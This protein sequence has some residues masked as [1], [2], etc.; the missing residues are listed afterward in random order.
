MTW[1]DCKVVPTGLLSDASTLPVAA[2]SVKVELLVENGLPA[3]PT[4]PAVEMTATLLPA[5]VTPAAVCRDLPA[6]L[7]A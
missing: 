6:A 3:V 5:T 4:E 2:F 7:V 1:L